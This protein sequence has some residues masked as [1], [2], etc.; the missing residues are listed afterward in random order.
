M[1]KYK[2]C[3]Y[4]CN[5]V[6]PDGREVLSIKNGIDVSTITKLSKK[7]ILYNLKHRSDNNSTGVKTPDTKPKAVKMA[8]LRRSSRRVYNTVRDLCLCNEF[9]LFLTLT[10][11]KKK[12][13]RLNDD[14]VRKAFEDWRKDVKTKFPAMTYI[15]VPEYHKKGGLHY[16]LLVGGISLYDLQPKFYEKAEC[17][18]QLIDVYSTSIWLNGWSTVSE[19]VNPEACHLYVMKYITKADADVRFH[20]KKRYHCSHNLKRPAVERVKYDGGL[21]DETYTISDMEKEMCIS[22]T[23]ADTEKGYYVYDVQN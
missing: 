10:F 22:L 7:Q 2:H 8:N 11:D 9:S 20:N 15:A 4:L 14:A 5:K 19:I 13:D 12:V 18:G 17:Q 6:Y 16:H 3:T 21:F 23:F 1:S